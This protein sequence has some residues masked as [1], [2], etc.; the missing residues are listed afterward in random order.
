MRRAG[1]VAPPRRLAVIDAARGLALCGM[2]AFHADWDLAYGGWIASGPAE[3]PVWS[4]FGQC[5]AVTFLALSGYSL[6]L[7][8]DRGLRAAVTRIGRVAAAAML[9]TGVT[10]W[11]FPQDVVTF[12]I[13]H[14]IA[15]S[16]LLALPL[17]R[18]P[19]AAVLGV[20]LLCLLAPR[21]WSTAA[22]DGPLWAW[23]GLGLS[24]PRTLDYRPL[25]PWMGAV[26]VGMATALSPLPRPGRRIRT[27]AGRSLAVLG[28]HSLLIYCLHQ[29]LLFGLVMLASWLHVAPLGQARDTSRQ[30][31]TRCVAEGAGEAGC[32]A[33]CRCL[34]ARPV[35]EPGVCL[36][37]SVPEPFRDAT[38]P[39]AQP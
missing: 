17:R 33:A 12:G 8:R 37:P 1:P 30:C 19:V 22:L 9:I 16:S 23:L 39:E 2:V 18:A 24:P 13:L 29:P 25:L 10:G 27:P 14:C 26:L 7:A 21:M 4:L 3:S 15:L 32:M 6:V 11:L 31:A 5:V 35:P 28:R 38:Q 34:L 20:A 36:A